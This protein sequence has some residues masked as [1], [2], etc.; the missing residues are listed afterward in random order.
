MS[1]S[2]I[3]YAADDGIA[4]VT[5]NRPARLNSF[6]EPMHEELRAALQ[7]VRSD[8][9]IRAMILTGAG[10]G[11]CAGQ[12]LEERRTAEGGAPPDLGDTLG[13]NYNPLVL[14]L[15]AMP[16]P[17]VCAIN[18]VAAGAGANLAL[19]GDIVI[20]ARSASFV[21]AFGRIGLV[22]DC[23]GSWYLPRLLGDARARAL[24]LLGEKLGAEDA[25]RWGLIW[26][27]VDDAELLNEARVL[28]TRLAVLPIR[29]LIETRRLLES[30]WA[31]DLPAQLERE[32]MT[33]K[34]LGESADYREG[35]AA[36]REKRAPRF[37]G[38]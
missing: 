17:V 38:R 6:T 31:N 25:E 22:P 33:Q 2:S 12:D 16:V 29:A 36:F 20:A 3:L 15:R 30:G 35:V 18:G 24:A 19:S 9:R 5:L 27:C 14:A 11:F 34:T 37:G 10:R 4:L 28:A 1:D 26:R 8:R 32:R 21:Q 7:R 13:R 23:G